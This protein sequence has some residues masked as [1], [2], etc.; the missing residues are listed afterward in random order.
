MRKPAEPV[1]HHRKHPKATRGGRRRLSGLWYLCL[2]CYSNV[3]YGQ[4]ERMAWRVPQGV[5]GDQRSQICASSFDNVVG[6]RH[7]GRRWTRS[8]GPWHMSSGKIVG[9]DDDD[10]FMIFWFCRG[11]TSSDLTVFTQAATAGIHKSV[12]AFEPEQQ[13]L[14]RGRERIEGSIGK[15][16][17]KG[18]MSQEDADQALGSIIFTTDMQDLK[19]TD[20]IVEA[21]TCV[22]YCGSIE[23]MVPVGSESEL[24]L[25]S[26]A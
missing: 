18:K 2:L 12:V 21:G 10:I 11:S 17:S 7:D 9:D 5:A 8:D 6:I 26:F 13:F 4:S 15:L 1:S 3:Q 19:D 23:A 25:N 20:F 22:V 14:D 16:V 24:T